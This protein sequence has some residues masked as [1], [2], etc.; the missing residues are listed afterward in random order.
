MAKDLYAEGL[1]WYAIPI[2]PGKKDL[3]VHNL[4]WLM[5]HNPYLGIYRVRGD[6]LDDYVLRGKRFQDALPR[7]GDARDYIFVYMNYNPVTAMYI[8]QRDTPLFHGKDLVEDVQILPSKQVPGTYHFEHRTEVYPP[9]KLNDQELNSLGLDDLELV[10]KYLLGEGAYEYELN[11]IKQ[12]ITDLKL[13]FAQF[14][15][16]KIESVKIK[17]NYVSF[18][19]H[20][21]SFIGITD[22]KSLDK[23][24]KADS[25]FGFTVNAV[26]PLMEPKTEILQTEPFDLNSGY[27]NIDLLDHYIDLIQNKDDE[28]AQEY[29]RTQSNN[30]YYEALLSQQMRHEFGEFENVSTGEGEEVQISNSN[31]E[32]SIETQEE[33]TPEYSLMDF[34]I[35][36]KSYNGV[37]LTFRIKIDDKI[38]EDY[39]IEEADIK[40]TIFRFIN[41]SGYNFLIENYYIPFVSERDKMLPSIGN[42][43]IAADIPPQGF[44]PKIHQKTHIVINEVNT[45][46]ISI[47]S[48]T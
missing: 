33:V 5:A 35:D 48:K 44:D 2:S 12:V 11:N 45:N 32:V 27:I 41:D 23:I 34:N 3:A 18:E 16:I 4:E 36:F 7:L 17:G 46:A 29:F 40:D 15:T 42:E 30:R 10:K 6:L 43:R 39:Y 8:T 22:D 14:F 24:L 19:L 9:I 20:G 47:S 13:C 26:E 37:K 1:G 25:S 31:D 21:G 28:K 38:I